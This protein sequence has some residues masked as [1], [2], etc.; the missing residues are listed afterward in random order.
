[1]FLNYPNN[2]TGAHSNAGL[3]RVRAVAY[4]P[5][6]YDILLC[7]DNAYSEMTFGGY[8]APSFL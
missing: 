8:R 5:R 7:H 1:M 4:L 2:P 6:A 3:H